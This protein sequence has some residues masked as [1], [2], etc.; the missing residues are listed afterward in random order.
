MLAVG[1]TA[2]RLL[3]QRVVQQAVCATCSWQAYSQ[4]TSLF[5]P[6]PPPL[7]PRHPLQR[8]SC[9]EALRQLFAQAM[10][11]LLQHSLDPLS[12]CARS[13]VA[14]FGRQVRGAGLAVVDLPVV[15][16]ASATSGLPAP[17]G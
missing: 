2:R 8:E 7:Q 5:P 6:S 11:K 3:S 12:S 4:A 1:R 10:P 13:V 16:Q 9:A 14:E 17:P 15:S